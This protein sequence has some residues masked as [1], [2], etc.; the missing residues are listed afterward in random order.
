M[1]M[2]RLGFPTFSRHEALDQGIGTHL[3]GEPDAKREHSAT[4]FKRA[5]RWGLRF[6]VAGHDHRGL[7]HTAQAAPPLSMPQDDKKSA[8]PTNAVGDVSSPIDRAED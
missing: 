3:A 6:R 5:S 1:V 8:C 4:G 2:D 7:K